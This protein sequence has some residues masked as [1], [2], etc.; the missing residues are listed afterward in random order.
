MT[1]TLR[2]N[3]SYTVYMSHK[4]NT[5]TT[6]VSNFASKFPRFRQNTGDGYWIDTVST[7]RKYTLQ[8]QNKEALFHNARKQCESA[9][10]NSYS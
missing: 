1:L 6:H 9:D 8:Q 4:I 10:R 7:K 2:A 5:S 3:V